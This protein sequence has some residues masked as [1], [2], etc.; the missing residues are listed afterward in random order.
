MLSPRR[1]DRADDRCHR[2]AQ[3][4]AAK[5]MIAATAWIQD[6]DWLADTMRQSWDGVVVSWGEVLEHP[7]DRLVLSK[8]N[9]L[10]AH[11]TE[12]LA[13]KGAIGQGEP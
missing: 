7:A 11:R 1:A 5:E 12:K 3:A 10:R 6:R 9:R 4:S 2:L 13:T 8:R